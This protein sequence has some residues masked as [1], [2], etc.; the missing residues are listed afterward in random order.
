MLKFTSKNWTLHAGAGFNQNAERRSNT[1]FN[2]VP[3]GYAAGTNGISTLLSYLLFSILPVLLEFA[4]VAAVLLGR[5][6][7]RF[8]A[9]TFAAVG[10]YI[11]F[12]LGFIVNILALTGGKEPPFW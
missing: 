9:V 2:G 12:T 8:A 7:W 11:A 5:F 10:V 6:D 4:L 1:I 3:A